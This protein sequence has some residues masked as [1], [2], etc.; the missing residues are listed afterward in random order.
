M[1]VKKLSVTPFITS[2][3]MAALIMATLMVA[4]YSQSASARS[5]LPEQNDAAAA[6]DAV[7]DSMSKLE[8]LNKRIKS[9]EAVVA[10]EQERL[11]QYQTEKAQTEQDLESRKAIFEQKSKVLDEAWKSRSNY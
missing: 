9:Q 10:K 6:R 2:S 1:Q 11:Q 8:D 7:G 3:V 5:I 4:T